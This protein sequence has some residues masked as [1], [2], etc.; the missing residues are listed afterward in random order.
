MAFTRN[1]FP[2]F[3]DAT[4]DKLLDSYPLSAIAASSKVQYATNGTTFDTALNVSSF[5]T[6]A[7]QMANNLY[8][9]TTF[10]CP[11]YWMAEAFTDKGR[12]AYKYQ[13]S[14]PG[15]QH[16]ADVL[17]YF[18]PPYEP[19]GEDFARAVRTMLGNFVIRDDPSI[20]AEVAQGGDPDAN[21]EAAKAW[22]LFSTA[23]P[24]EL[25]LNNTGGTL[26]SA[27][28]TVP[29]LANITQTKDPG[30]KNDFQA[31]D[32]F[33]REGGRGKRCD[34]WRSVGSLVPE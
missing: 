5:A 3:D 13:Y 11:A 20:S 23:S 1:T 15:A 19:Q 12:K 4:I 17:A 26:Y 34:F 33:K 22:P 32:A 16:G 6:G 27:D 18:G 21:I 24:L 28:S 30:L 29:G 8:A 2:L 25:N 7:Q 14:V 31:V 10:V 9:E